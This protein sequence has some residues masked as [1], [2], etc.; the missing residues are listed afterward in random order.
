M[1]NFYPLKG[2]GSSVTINTTDFNFRCDLLDILT[3]NIKSLVVH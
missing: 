2:K 1:E 3:V